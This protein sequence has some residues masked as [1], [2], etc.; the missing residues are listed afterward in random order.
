ME[1]KQERIKERPTVKVNR[2]VGVE[3]FL[4]YWGERNGW[5]TRQEQ[6]EREQHS[7]Q[8]RKEHPKT[9]NEQDWKEITKTDVVLG[10]ILIVVILYCIYLYLMTL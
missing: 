10:I 9:T 8:Y 6:K 1:D 7:E 5:E 3:F 4:N 2:K